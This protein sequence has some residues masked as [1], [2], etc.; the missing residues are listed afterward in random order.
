MKITK[1]QLKQIIK[2]ELSRVLSEVAVPGQKPVDPAALAAEAERKKQ[3]LAAV[4]AQHPEFS[5]APDALEWIYRGTFMGPGSAAFIRRQGIEK[6]VAELMGDLENGD[7]PG[8]F[9]ADK[10]KH[11]LDLAKEEQEPQAPGTP[12]TF[13]FDP[14]ASL[15]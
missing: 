10:W 12:S 8:W 7:L 1:Q 14:L 2:E 15:K 6:F 3:F 5:N 9:G 4:A 11:I 13:R